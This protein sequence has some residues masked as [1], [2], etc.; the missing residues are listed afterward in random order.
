MGSAEAV[1]Y[2][3]VQTVLKKDLKDQV[4]NTNYYTCSNK[5]CDLV[6]LSEDH[7][8]MF[9]AQDIDFTADFNEVIR[10]QKSCNGCHDKCGK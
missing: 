4:I 7:Q 1:H 10:Q 3:V 9:L 2:L 5:D 8:Q 6:F